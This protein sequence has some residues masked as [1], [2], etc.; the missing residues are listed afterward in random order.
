[1]LLYVFVIM[2]V[3]CRSMLSAVDVYHQ[4][5]HLTDQMLSN[6][7]V[8]GF[9]PRATTTMLATLKVFPLLLDVRI[10][11]KFDI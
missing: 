8:Q 5:K 3:S 10:G 7:I 4:Q 9:G 6:V 1:M 2:F 11:F